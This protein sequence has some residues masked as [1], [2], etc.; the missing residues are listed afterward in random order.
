MNNRLSRSKLYHFRLTMSRLYLVKLKIAQQQ[1]TAYWTYA[2][3]IANKFCRK[4]FHFRFSCLLD[5]SFSSLLTEN[6]LHFTG[7][8]EKFIF[9]LNVVKFNVVEI[10]SKYITGCCGVFIFVLVGAKLIKI[11]QEQRELW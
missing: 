3:P 2:E 5:N 1:P 7:V 6:F 4:S 11:D 9:K 10:S 8:Y